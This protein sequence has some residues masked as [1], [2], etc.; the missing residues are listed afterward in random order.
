VLAPLASGVGEGLLE[1]ARGDCS[2]ALGH[3]NA[4]DHHVLGLQVQ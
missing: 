4:V 3:R 1:V 2:V